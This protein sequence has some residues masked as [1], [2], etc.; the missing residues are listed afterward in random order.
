M[1]APFTAGAVCTLLGLVG[2]V[3][4][5]VAPYPGRAF[6]ITVLMVGLTLL[7]VGKGWSA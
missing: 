7:A 4:G 2:Y 1:N 5:I 3:F 6:A